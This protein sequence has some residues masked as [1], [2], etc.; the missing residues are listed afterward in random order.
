[1]KKLVIPLD[2]ALNDLKAFLVERGAKLGRELVLLNYNLTNRELVIS[3]MAGAI[4]ELQF[5]SNLKKWYALANITM[6]NNAT[7]YLDNTP[8]NS[9]KRFYRLKLLD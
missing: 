8:Q 2:F 3:G 4:Y 5:S 6:K 1:M 9:S 7:V